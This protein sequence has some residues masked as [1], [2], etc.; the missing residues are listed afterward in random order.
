MGIRIDIPMVLI[1]FTEGDNGFFLPGFLKAIRGLW[2]WTNGLT[3][4]L[5][6]KVEKKSVIC[7]VAH[8]SSLTVLVSTFKYYKLLK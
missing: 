2:V 6:S 3:T 4:A 8:S 5:L 7:L 1:V